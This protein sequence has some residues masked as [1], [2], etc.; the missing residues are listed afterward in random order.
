MSG[1]GSMHPPAL[2][3]AADHRPRGVPTIERYGDYLAALRAALPHCD[4]IL[5]TAQPLADLAASGSLGPGHRT[6]LSI[7]R[8]GLAGSAFELDDRLVASVGRAASDGWT[9]V[10]LMTRIATDDPDGAAALEL[11]GRVLEEA[12]AAG[13]EALIEPVLWRDGRMSRVTDDIVLAAVD[14]PRSGRAAPE[15]SGP[16][17]GAGRPA[18]RRRSTGWWTAWAS[19]S[20]SSAARAGR[21]HEDVVELARDVMRRRR[22]GPG[23]RPAGHRGPRPGRDGPPAGRRRPRPVILTLDLGTTVTKASLWSGTGW[24]IWPRWRSPPGT[25]RRGG[26][27]R[28]PRSGGASVVSA[29]ARLADQV[30]G[31]LAGVGGRGVHRGPPDLRAVR[32]RRRFTRSRTPVVRPPGH[33]TS[34]DRGRPRRPPAIR[35][36]P[37]RCRPNSPGWPPTDRTTGPGRP[38]S[39]A[40]RDLVVWRLTGRV[41]TDPSLASCTGLYDDGGTVVGG[42]GRRGRAAAA[43]RPLGRGHRSPDGRLG[44]GARS[45]DRGRRW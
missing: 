3:L 15:G 1:T 4:G 42:G 7:N 34:A 45:A 30:P 24:S 31:G 41:A 35:R 22:G 9:G 12:V 26:P 32:R 11:L 16:R 6:Y 39:S 25:R 36:T 29:C 8:T 19:R 21:G 37:G 13:L 27:S 23:C 17:R 18:G 2:V 28:T 33:G 38:G 44:V 43:G 40:P 10:K 5:A 14:R 20:S